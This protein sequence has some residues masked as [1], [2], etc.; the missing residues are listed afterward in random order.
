MWLA[1]AQIAIWL[2]P[3][4]PVEFT[5]PV[6]PP[7]AQAPHVPFPS[8]QLDEF[9]VPVPNSLTGT[10]PEIR[11]AFPANPASTYCFGVACIA[12]TGFP[13]RLIGPLIVPPA[14]DR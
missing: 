14:V 5:F 13:A 7:L 1:S 11:S 6:P 10:R 4:V 12:E 8:K 3:G 9:A 2:L